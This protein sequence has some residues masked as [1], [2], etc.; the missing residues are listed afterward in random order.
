MPFSCFCIEC[1]DTA[2]L[3]IQERFGNFVR[4]LPPGAHLICWPIDSV[5]G[6]VSGRVQQFAC[7]CGTKTKDNV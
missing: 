5:N 3:G 6:R 2:T 4:V 1:I 7:D